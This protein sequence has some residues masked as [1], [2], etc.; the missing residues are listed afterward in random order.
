[1]SDLDKRRSAAPSRRRRADRAYNLV[2]ATG[3]LT[4]L[5]VALVVLAVLGI[6]GFGL[7]VIVALLAA[8]AGLLLRRTLNP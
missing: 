5:A 3:G 1:M 4:V 2:L 8:A 7:A 6:V